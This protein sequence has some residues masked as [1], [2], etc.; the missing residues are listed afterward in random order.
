MCA[1]MND[2]LQDRIKTHPLTLYLIRYLVVQ[3]NFPN[4][5]FRLRIIRYGII[6][7]SRHSTEVFDVDQGSLIRPEIR[8]E[9][10]K[11]NHKRVM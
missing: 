3:V 9:T 4:F 6:S 8:K 1:F 11:Q 5:A 10:T 7:I 2:L